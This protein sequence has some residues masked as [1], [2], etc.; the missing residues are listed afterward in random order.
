MKKNR[1]VEATQDDVALLLTMIRELAD[2]EGCS[3]EVIATEEGLT[4]SL[5]GAKATAKVLIT[6]IEGRP[7]G[8]MIY[9]F[10]FAS[11]TG[12]NELYLQNIYLREEARDLGLG[13]AFMRE[14][15]AI[16][17]KSGATRIEWCVEETN[18]KALSFYQ[19]L[20]AKVSE[21]IKVVRLDGQSLKSLGD[22]EG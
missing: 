4:E 7:V 3:D 21:E 1:T 15:A 9:C 22:Q 11:F 13:L 14:L 16:S 20:G 5:F 19:Q 18:T 2:W 8:Y 6:Y 17:K 12:R 10:K